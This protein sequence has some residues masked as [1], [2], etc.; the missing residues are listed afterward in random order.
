[1]RQL[2]LSWSK[3]IVA[4]KVEHFKWIFQGHV[5]FEKE[6]EDASLHKLN[7]AVAIVVDLLQQRKGTVPTPLQNQ[8]Y[9]DVEL[10]DVFSLRVSAVT[11]SFVL[12]SD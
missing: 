3:Q 4:M 6:K 11:L 8:Q 9:C 1:M 7:E 5:E 2:G 12:P 10:E